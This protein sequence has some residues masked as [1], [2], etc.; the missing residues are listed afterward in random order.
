MAWTHGMV[1]RAECV[2]QTQRLVSKKRVAGADEGL[3]ERWADA[4]AHMRTCAPLL[5]ARPCRARL[6]G[7]SRGSPNARCDSPLSR[8]LRASS[9]MLH[10]MGPT[11]TCNLLDRSISG[12][13]RNCALA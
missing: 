13:A 7:T 10:A 4:D 8:M 11:E 5:R 3:G 1:F 2:I 12:S 6:S 9:A